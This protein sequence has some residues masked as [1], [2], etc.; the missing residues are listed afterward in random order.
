[1]MTC[2]KARLRAVSRRHRLGQWGVGLSVPLCVMFELEPA[3]ESPEM[4][5][6]QSACDCMSG[7][8]TL[9][10]TVGGGPG[11]GCGLR[12]APETSRE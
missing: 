12:L 8:Q 11:P 10:G 3:S 7:A 6:Q 2:S 1:M 9:Y 5:A 4:F